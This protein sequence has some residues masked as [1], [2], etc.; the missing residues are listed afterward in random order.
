MFSYSET[1]CHSSSNIGLKN[2]GKMNPSTSSMDIYNVSEDGG[3]VI[4]IAMSWWVARKVDARGEDFLNNVPWL[5][6]HEMQIWTPTTSCATYLANRFILT[7]SVSIYITVYLLFDGCDYLI[8]QKK[9]KGNILWNWLV[10]TGPIK[11]LRTG[12][13]SSGT[14]VTWKGTGWMWKRSWGR[15]QSSEE[16][17]RAETDREGTSWVL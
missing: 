3:R 15:T 6:E 8:S 5:W 7:D 16:V 11:S 17:S 1:F 2:G 4:Q 12:I 13:P 9:E 14:L 10:S